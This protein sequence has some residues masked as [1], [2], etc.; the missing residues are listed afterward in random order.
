[1]RSARPT[2]ALALLLA[3]FCA[4]VGVGSVPLLSAARAD[5]VDDVC[6]DLDAALASWRQRADAHNNAPH[7]FNQYQQAQK[8]AY[9]AEKARLEQEQTQLQSRLRACE[10]AAEAIVPNDSSG[11]P[12]K[13]TAPPG[14]RD[15]L[16]RA[17]AAIPPNW[18][19]P[20][21][22]PGQKAEV[23]K[24]SPLRPVYDA[25]RA[26]NPGAASKLGDVSLQGQPRPRPGDPDPAYPGTTIRKGA[27]GPEVSGDHIVPLAELVQ[28]PGFTRLTPDQ[29][30]MLS[31]TP[32]NLQWLSWSAN[33]AKGAG[34]AAALVPKVDAG[35]AAAQGRLE[36]RTRA[37]LQDA[38]NKLI[39]GQG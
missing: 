20:A 23:P 6:P 19:P 5:P 29:M 7:V 34:S 24:D 37:T 32:A 3:L 30:Y 38:I 35:W 18:R 4:L 22:V 15:A 36:E 25:V 10:S 39:A 11:P 26:G 33:Q 2:R 31:R 27:N 21:R 28:M 16:R 1:M 17:Q 8:Q 12:L 13:T 9:N 14:V